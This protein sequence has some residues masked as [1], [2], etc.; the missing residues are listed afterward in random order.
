[1]SRIR[2][3]DRDTGVTHYL[4]LK[5]DNTLPFK[6]LHNSFPGA[7]G[8]FTRSADPNEIFPLVADDQMVISSLSLYL[9][10]RQMTS[11]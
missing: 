11:V 5:P 2:I 8:L 4:I 9:G 3:L 6:T 7:T 10:L 1:M